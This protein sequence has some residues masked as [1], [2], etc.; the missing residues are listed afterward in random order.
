MV[1]KLNSIIVLLSLVANPDQEL[2][3]VDIPNTF[4]NGEFDEEIYIKVPPNFENKVLEQ[5]L[6]AWFKRFSLIVKSF[7]YSKGQ[8]NHTLLSKHSHEGKVSTLVIYVN[9]IIIT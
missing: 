9:D 6:G 3:Q 7:K 2:H 5:S 1:A 4:L 8:A